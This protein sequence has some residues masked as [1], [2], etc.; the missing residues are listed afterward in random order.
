MG[1][2]VRALAR[3][4][5]ECACTCVHVW[6]HVRVPTRPGAYQR[7][8]ALQRGTRL[9]GPPCGLEAGVIGATCGGQQLLH[10]LLAGSLENS[11][12]A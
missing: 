2:R 12:S 4:L 3:G 5:G 10:H 1:V 9:G 6:V 8:L 7:S 11:V